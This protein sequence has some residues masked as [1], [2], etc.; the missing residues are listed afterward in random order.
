MPSSDSA[1]ASQFQAIDL[2]AVMADFFVA[3]GAVAVSESD[4][5]RKSKA[6]R[7]DAVFEI[8]R[9]DA[10]LARE[11][12][13]CCMHSQP[14]LCTASSSYRALKTLK[15]SF[16]V[17]RQLCAQFSDSDLGDDC[18]AK[19][20]ATGEQTSS[21]LKLTSMLNISKNRST[22]PMGV[23]MN[24]CLAWLLLQGVGAPEIESTAE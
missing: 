16:K 6:S 21:R 7:L 1:T 5:L 12:L 9:A 4:A 13:S 11:R 22:I 10:T 15:P 17:H 8:V 2:R 20:T 23:A 14:V 18:R 3:C 24:A 19:P